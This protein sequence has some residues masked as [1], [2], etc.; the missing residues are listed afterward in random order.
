[1]NKKLT[2]SLASV[3][4]LSSSLYAGGD[5]VEEVKP[6]AVTEVLE[7]QYALGLKVGTL[8]LGLDISKKISD[9]LNVR[10]NINGATYSDTQCES[11]IKY[12]YDLTLATAG[13]LV[14]YFPIANNFRVS[15]G[16]YYNANEFELTAVPNGGTYNIN[17]TLYTTNQIGSLTGMVDFDE[18]APYIGIGWGNSIKTKGWGFSVDAGIL[19]H[20]EPNVALVANCGAVACSDVIINN[21]EAERLELL[22]ELSDYKIYPVI[23]V[24]VTYTF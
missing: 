22:N 17:N 5:F 3:A 13:L 4:A 18:L 14:D 15:V 20:G 8:G 24:G 12:D 2:L 21:V 1:M 16:A 10:L 23:S 19:Y 11:N 7:S 9:K 6:I